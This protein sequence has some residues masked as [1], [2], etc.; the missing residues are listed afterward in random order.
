MFVFG[1]TRISLKCK[2]EDQ[3]TGDL[4]VLLT[5]GISPSIVFSFVRDP[6]GKIIEVHIPFESFRAAKPVV[7]RRR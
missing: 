7:F 3:F 1:R 2:G 6:S 4:R 5:Y